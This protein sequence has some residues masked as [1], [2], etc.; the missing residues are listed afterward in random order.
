MTRNLSG[1]TMSANV[2]GSFGT[3]LSFRIRWI[4]RCDYVYCGIIA[5]ASEDNLNLAS[6]M[7][8]RDLP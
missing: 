2:M 5:A 4:E 6:C 8:N 7:T 3:L 1:I